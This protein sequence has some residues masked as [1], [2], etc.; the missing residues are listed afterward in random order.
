MFETGTGTGVMRKEAERS[1]QRG[2]TETLISATFFQL[3]RLRCK[4]DNK[5]LTP[6]GDDDKEA[7]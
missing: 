6:L 5:L 2:A 1:S 3:Y 7:K 4:I